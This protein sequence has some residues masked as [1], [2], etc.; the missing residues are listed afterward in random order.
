M[1]EKIIEI[2]FG[3]NVT[4]TINEEAV[5][6]IGAC[7]SFGSMIIALIG[8][9]ISGNNLRLQRKIY[10]ENKPNFKMQEVLD[11]YIIYDES[12]DVVQLMF[13]PLIINNS[14]KPLI[15]EKIR[16]NLI[17][18]E[19]TIVLRPQIKDEYI[20][21]GYNIPGFNADTHWICFEMGC[22]AYVDLKIIKHNLTIEDTLNNAQTVSMTWLKEMV[23][24]K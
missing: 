18:E 22:T 17:G 2:I 8:A 3:N 24:K 16:L 1:L 15:L 19:Q 23:R 14:S 6:I 9:I 21:D 12:Q 10:D 4:I 7:I 20:N 13:Y 5:S 11:S